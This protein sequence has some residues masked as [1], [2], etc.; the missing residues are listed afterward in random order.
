MNAGCSADSV[1]MPQPLYM[2]C[3]ISRSTT[4]A[5]ALRRHDA[6]P[7][8]VPEIGRDGQHL[9]LLAV[10][11]VGVEA[12]SSSQKSSLNCSNSVAAFSRS[13][14]ARSLVAERVED[15]GHAQPGVVDIAL[16][17]AQRLR[18]P[19]RR[20]VGI[21]HGI[22]GVLPRHVLVADRRA[23]LV[24]LEAVAVAIAVVVDP[25]QAASAFGKMPLQQRR[26]PVARQAACS[27]IRYSGVASA[28]P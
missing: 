19:H 5:G 4:R 24:F 12:V 16:Q 10:Q 11:H 7:Q 15:L 27:V 21:D 13:A 2:S 23:R 26:S 17:F 18:P 28:V 3:A 1:R 20:A 25:G 14:V 6:G 8:A 22:A 9:L